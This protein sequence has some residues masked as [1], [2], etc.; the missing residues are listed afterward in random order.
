MVVSTTVKGQRFYPTW[1]LIMSAHYTF[2]KAGN[3][4]DT[5]VR[6]K[7]LYYSIHELH[8]L[9]Q[10]L[11]HLKNQG[12]MPNGPGVC[13]KVGL[14]HSRGSLNLEKPQSYKVAF[15]K[16]SQHLPQREILLWLYWT[17]ICLLPWREIPAPLSAFASETSLKR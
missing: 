12:A 6:D 3:R 2:I 8:I 5:W 9:N 4:P 15:S 13:C 11:F 14:H 17:Q 10:F 16:P 1:K 7:E